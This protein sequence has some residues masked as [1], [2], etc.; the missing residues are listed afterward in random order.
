M[1]LSKIAL[2]VTVL[3][4]SV[5]WTGAAQAIPAFARKEQAACNT[6]HNA[7]PMVNSVGRM[8]KENGYTFARGGEGKTEKISDFLEWDKY[9]P[10]AALFNSRPYDKKDSGDSKL[11]AIHEI[12][13]FVAGQ[14][15]KSSSAWFEIEAED[16]EDFAASM[17]FA[18][19][20]YHPSAA[21]NVQAA[22]API[23]WADPYDTYSTT[24]RMTGPNQPQV[25]NQAYGGADRPAASD[26]GRLR[27]RRQMVSVYGRP[28]A[29]LFYNVGVSSVTDDSEGVSPDT[30]FARVAFDAVPGTM[31]GALVIDGTCKV[32]IAGRL[33]CLVDRDYRRTSVDVQSDIGPARVMAV[34]L[35]AEDD[36]ATAT[37][38]VKNNAW[39]VQGLYAFQQGGRPTWVPLLRYDSYEKSNG[40]EEYGEAVLNLPY[41]FTQNVKGSAEYM[42]QLDVPT[43]VVEDSRFTL[44]LIAA[45]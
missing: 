23:T 1:H 27:D 35:K 24:R 3:A 19:V 39:Y 41:Y 22:W 15:Y 29:P 33:N 8:Y 30:W 43:G 34:Y 9:F 28:L 16:E 31:I 21:V 5:V 11:R 32:T 38:T 18:A 10:A 14:I 7:W 2:A 20:A 4:A 42:K 45:F 13:L 26:G 36:D 6:C 12:E 25:I 17:K 37:A 40:T 44:Q